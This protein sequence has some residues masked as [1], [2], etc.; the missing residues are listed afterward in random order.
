M[1]DPEFFLDEG[2]SAYDHPTRLL[3]IGLWMLADDN[4]ATLPNRPEWIKAQ[5]FP[6][7]NVDANKMISTLIK[8]KKLIEFTDKESGKKFLFIANF[9]RYQRV[10]KPAKP[11]FP[12]YNREGVATV[13]LKYRDEVKLSKNKLSKDKISYVHFE[14]FWTA[15]PKKI[16]KKTAYAV[17]QKINPSEELTENIVQAVVKSR[18]TQDW[19]KDG[20]QFIPHPTTYL[21][22][23]RWDDQVEEKKIKSVNLK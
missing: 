18:K 12:A 6:Y 11:K 14:K 17:W 10:D 19:L 3:Y 22:Q 9:H 5:I 1:I 8:D 16:G 4:Y 15:Y 7:D 2:I 21:H 23:E 20:G 13:S